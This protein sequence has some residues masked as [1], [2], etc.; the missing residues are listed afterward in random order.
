MQILFAA[1]V[2]VHT[3][4]TSSIESHPRKSRFSSQ[5]RLDQP[6]IPNQRKKKNQKS[7]KKKKKMKE[8]R[9]ENEEINRLA[10]LLSSFRPVE[11]AASAEYIGF[12]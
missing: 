6:I 7:E 2:D 12:I 9:E 5:P 8:E 3:A 11:T 4:Q 1:T 10:G